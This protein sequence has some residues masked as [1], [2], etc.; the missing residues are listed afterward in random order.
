[1]TV[2]RSIR[3]LAFTLVGIGF[4]WVGKLPGPGPGSFS[5]RGQKETSGFCLLGGAGN[6]KNI[7]RLCPVVGHLTP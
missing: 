3:I 7:Q 1:M 6:K 5:W 4:H 2:F